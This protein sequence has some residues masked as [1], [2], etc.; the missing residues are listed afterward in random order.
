MAPGVTHK[1]RQRLFFAGSPMSTITQPITQLSSLNGEKL[2]GRGKA[3]SS[4]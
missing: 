2:K 4:I 3:C 1:I